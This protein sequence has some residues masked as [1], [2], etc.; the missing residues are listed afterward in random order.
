MRFLLLFLPDWYQGVYS[1]GPCDINGLKTGKTT[2]HSVRTSQG[3]SYVIGGQPMEI[4]VLGRWSCD[5]I[6]RSKIKF[7]YLLI[8]GGF[9]YGDLAIMG[10]VNIQN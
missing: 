5:Y 3:R 1:G 9:V 4:M 7:F 8:D 2:C 6:L 10:K